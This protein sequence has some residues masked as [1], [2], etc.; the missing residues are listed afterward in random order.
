MHVLEQSDNFAE[1]FAR[2]LQCLLW[3]L[4]RNKMNNMRVVTKRSNL[5]SGHIFFRL[6]SLMVVDQIE[7]ELVSHL[8]VSNVHKSP[9]V[10]EK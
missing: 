9:V 3:H 10:E 7:F 1:G 5:D 2:Y 4:Q 8:T 6:V